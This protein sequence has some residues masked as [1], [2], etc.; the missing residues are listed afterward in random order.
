[1]KAKRLILTIIPVAISAATITAFSMIKPRQTV[2]IQVNN[3]TDNSGWYDLIREQELSGYD[4]LIDVLYKINEDSGQDVISFYTTPKG[5]LAIYDV[6]GN[7]I[8]NNPDGRWVVTSWE[9][10]SCQDQ[11][12]LDGWTIDQ[13]CN[14]PVEFISMENKENNGNWINFTLN[15]ITNY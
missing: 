4:Y 5:D 12:E 14:I 3:H 10:V 8:S 15:F 6:W 7:G 13:Y 2:S 1:M 9:S 11:L